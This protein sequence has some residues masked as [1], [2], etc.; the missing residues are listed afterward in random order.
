MAQPKAKPPFTS[1]PYKQVAL[2][3][4]DRELAFARFSPCGKFLFGGSYDSRIYRWTLD[5]IEKRAIEAHNGWP[6][7][8]LFHPDGQRMFTAD[9]WGGICCWNYA[10]A[11]PTPLWTK[12][13][14]HAR[15]MRS[16]AIDAEGKRLATCGAD[17][18]VRTHSTDDGKLL[19]ERSLPEDLLSI[20][21]HPREAALLVGDLKGRITHLDPGD[22]KE[23]RRLDA[24]T[25]YSRPKV[26]GFTEINDV[27]GVR[28]MAF[29]A[30]GTTL[31]AG[32]S[33]PAT[34]G[35]FTGKP[36]VVCFDWRSGKQSQLMQW[37]GV[38][39]DE[40]LVL[41]LTPSPDGSF[42]LS[43]SGQPGKGA[44]AVWKPGDAKPLHL[45]K[46][47]PHCRTTSLHANRLALTQ[48]LV[49]PGQSAGNGRRL[50][51]DGEYV[52]LVSQIRIFERA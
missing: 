46:T 27:G 26:N 29:D 16:L 34:S 19:A 18:F 35:F 4:H 15:W 31:A 5:T 24:S 23:I 42:L 32:G 21:F 52:G 1:G 43:T 10:D 41:D 50:G 11:A 28:T 7:G 20:L 12:R 2:L 44:F 37:D 17:R 14:T 47:L 36:T 30:T 49:K 13:D 33:Q 40:G 48:V 45:D 6:Q 39:P 38:T 51:K 25:L 22:L 3:E 9:S 8:L